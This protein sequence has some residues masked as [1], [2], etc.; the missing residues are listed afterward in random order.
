MQD[1]KESRKQKPIVWREHGLRMFHESEERQKHDNWT[2]WL[3][4]NW[5]QRWPDLPLGDEV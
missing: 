2:D 1:G 3:E 4:T 5:G